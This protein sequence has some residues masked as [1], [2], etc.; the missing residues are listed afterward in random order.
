MSQ[1]SN[2]SR[3]TK[4]SLTSPIT[5]SKSLPT[6]NHSLVS[7]TKI[8]PS[9]RRSSTSVAENSNLGN[10]S[11]LSSSKLTAE[12]RSKARDIVLG[13]QRK[14][15][16]LVA[17]DFD[18]TFLSIHTGGFYQ[19]TPDSLLEHIRSTFFYLIQEILD[20]PAFNQTLHLCIVSFSSQDY[21]IKKLLRLAF[22]T[23]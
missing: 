2:A 4:T 13:L 6:S 10:S 9:N 16:K 18:N 19:G 23:S 3:S 12:Q 7:V 15:I 1:L 20:S 5:Q 22:K 21:L 11:R 17:V 8:K 14:N